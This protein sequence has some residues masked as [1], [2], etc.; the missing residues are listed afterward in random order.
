MANL[1]LQGAFL[2]FCI[3]FP[4]P[5]Y[6]TEYVFSKKFFRFWVVWTFFW[7][8]GAA[9]TITLM[10]V[11]QGRH[12]LVAFYQSVFQGKKQET[13]VISGVEEYSTKDEKMG[14]QPISKVEPVKDEL[15]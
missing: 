1:Y 9:G 10:P 13:T 8:I 14:Q 3:L 4:M 7:A 5:L 2:G 11:I 12:S 6:G 15:E